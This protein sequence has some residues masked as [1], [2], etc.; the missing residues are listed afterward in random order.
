M[1]GKAGVLVALPNFTN[2]R[3]PRKGVVQIERSIC[4]GKLGVL[5]PSHPIGFPT[6]LT[7]LARCSKL[8][9]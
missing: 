9:L 7:G 8:S 6:E 5:E 4:A 3:G 2:K 1:V